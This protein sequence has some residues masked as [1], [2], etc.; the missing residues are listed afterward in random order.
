MKLKIFTRLHSI[1]WFN[2]LTS[3]LFPPE[4]TKNITFEMGITNWSL[5]IGALPRLRLTH[6]TEDDFENEIKKHPIPAGGNPC[7]PN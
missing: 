5:L 3:T 1:S 6:P 4:I 2:R 7:F